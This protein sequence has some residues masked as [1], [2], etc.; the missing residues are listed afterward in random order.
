M[1]QKKAEPDPFEVAHELA[2]AA[3]GGPLF[4]P[5][6]LTPNKPKVLTSKSA[7]SKKVTRPGQSKGKHSRSRGSIHKRRS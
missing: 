7:K 2:E 1:K 5:K 3:I 6:K 4:T